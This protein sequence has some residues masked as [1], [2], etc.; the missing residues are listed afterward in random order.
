[1]ILPRKE[2]VDDLVAAGWERKKPGSDIWE[3]PGNPDSS[4]HGAYQAW[5]AHQ[6]ALRLEVLKL[7]ASRLGCLP[8][9][10]QVDKPRKRGKVVCPECGHQLVDTGT[11][12]KHHLESAYH[13]NAKRIM[14][15][16]ETPCITYTEIAERLGISKQRVSQIASGLIGLKGRYRVSVCAI[17]RHNESM[18]QTLPGVV[19]AKCIEHGL[20]AEYVRRK[21]WGYRQAE[22]LIDGIPAAI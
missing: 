4:Y 8:K 3:P 6:R 10:S 20:S 5:R 2:I 15:L 17:E 7:E 16:L 18:E 12:R 13:T 11:G 22:L 1:M 14:A 19:R 21:P 9:K